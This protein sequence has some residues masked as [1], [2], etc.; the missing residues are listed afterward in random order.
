VESIINQ[1]YGN[2]E[3]ILVDDGST[4]DSRKMCDEFAS[5]DK[6]V[7]VIHKHNGGSSSSREA[8][9]NASSGEYILFVDGDDWMDLDIISECV[10]CAESYKTDCVLFSYTKEYIDRSIP[11][12]LFGSTQLL[13]GDYG[14]DKVYRRFFGLVGEELSEPLRADSIVSCCMKLYRAENA[15]KGIYVDTKLVGSGE[16]ALFNIHALHGA[17]NFYYL[18]RPAYHYRKTNTSSLTKIYRP[19]LYQQWMTLFS[20]MDNAIAEYDLGHVYYEALSNR[21]SLSIIGF[22]LNAIQSPYRRLCYKNLREYV[23]D[24]RFLG[25]INTFNISRA[26][27]YIGPLMLCCRWRLVGLVYLNL[28][29]ANKL[30]GRK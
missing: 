29:I 12:S 25:A 26:P 28:L 21:V 4:D 7:R 17:E 15:K 18:D 20:M 10:S 8:G 3:I 19:E 30:K 16:D 1:S 2:L 6:R 11:V 27:F 24:K 22:G 5:S 14:V 23:S 9:I 13:S